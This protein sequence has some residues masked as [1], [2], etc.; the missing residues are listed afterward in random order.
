MLSWAGVSTD[1]LIEP[2]VLVLEGESLV[3][4]MDLARSNMQMPL[5]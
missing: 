3:G 5:A 1:D 2:G 4:E